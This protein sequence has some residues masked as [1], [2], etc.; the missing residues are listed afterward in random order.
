[1]ILR[2]IEALSVIDGYSE[3]L[4][5][6]RRLLQLLNGLIKFPDKV[7]VANSCITAAVLVANILSDA[8]NLV[9]EIIKDL[10]FLQGLLDIFPFASDDIEARSAIWSTVARLLVHVRESEMSPSNLH[11]YVSVLVSKSDLIEEELLDHQ[12]SVANVDHE[13]STA[14]GT[15]PNA[16]NIALG[17]IYSILNEWKTLKDHVNRSNCEEEEPVNEIDVDRLKDCCCKYGK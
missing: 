2:T 1:M 8:D 12:L 9:L 5:S 17:R 7:E 3:E 13:S 10:V 6:N 14:S 15:K 16:R 4:C 11:Q